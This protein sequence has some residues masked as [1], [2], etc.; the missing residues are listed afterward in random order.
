MN[1]LERLQYAA[2]GAVAAA[3]LILFLIEV[4]K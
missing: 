3:L 1:W 4:N 2:Y